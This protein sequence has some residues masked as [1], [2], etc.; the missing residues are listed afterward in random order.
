ME[1]CEWVYD[2]AESQWRTQQVV[3][4]I[5]NTGIKSSKILHE[6]KIELFE[7]FLNSASIEFL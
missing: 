7:K 5:K 2:A 4:E 6:R 1:G 3:N